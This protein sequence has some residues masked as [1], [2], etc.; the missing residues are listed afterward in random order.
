[1]TLIEGVVEES[2][3]RP[4]KSSAPMTSPVIGGTYDDDARTN[5]QRLYHNRLA[6]P[7]DERWAAQIPLASDRM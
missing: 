3:L 2:S 7:A 5:T 4:R 6:Y 1:M